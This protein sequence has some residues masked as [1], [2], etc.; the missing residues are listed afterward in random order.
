MRT[1][2][3]AIEQTTSPVTGDPLWTVVEYVDGK[4]TGGDW[5]WVRERYAQRA[6]AMYQDD[7]SLH[8]KPASHLKMLGLVC[9]SDAEH[10]AQ[11][12][13]RVTDD[14]HTVW[15]CCESSIGPDCPHKTAR[16]GE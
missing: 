3:Y 11:H 14:G 7:P 9:E 16:H 1:H 6:M 8:G 12:Y 2:T 15:A 4:P 10:D 5:H 13:P